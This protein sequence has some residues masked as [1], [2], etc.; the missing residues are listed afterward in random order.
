MQNAIPLKGF[1]TVQPIYQ[2]IKYL[3]KTETELDIDSD[4]MMVISPDEAVWAV[5]CTLPTFWVWIWVCSISA[6]IIPAL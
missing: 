6:A 5:L 4:H 1:E 3:L 2:F